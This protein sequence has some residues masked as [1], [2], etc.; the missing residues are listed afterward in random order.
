MTARCRG[1]TSAGPFLDTPAA[2]HWPANPTTAATS[3][4]RRRIDEVAIWNRRFRTRNSACSTTAARGRRWTCAASCADAYSVD[5]DATLTVDAASG[6]LAN[7]GPQFGEAISASVVSG[8][9]HGTLAI[10]R[11]RVVHLHASRELFW[12]RFVRLPDHEQPARAAGRGRDDHGQRLGDLPVAVDDF[13]R[14]REGQVLN[15]N[16]VP[17]PPVDTTLVAAG[18]V[19]KYL[20]NGSDQGTGWRERDFDDSALGSG[21]AELGYGDGGEAT[22]VDCGPAQGNECAAGNNPPNKYITTYFRRQFTIDDPSRVAG[23]SLELKRDDGAVV[24]INGSEVLRDNMG[25]GAINYLTTA[26]QALPDDGG[27][28]FPFS[29]IDRTS[30]VSGEN[31]IAV[32]IHQQSQQSSDISFDLRLDGMISPL[33]PIPGVLA[34]DSDPDGGTLTAVI[35]SLPDFGSLTFNANG[36]FVYTPAAGFNGTDAF[37]YRARNATGDSPPATVEIVVIPASNTPPTAV[38]DAYAVDEDGELIVPPRRGCWRTTATHRAI[39]C[40]R[41]WSP[42]RRTGS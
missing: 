18:S 10:G 20:D 23:L 14:T 31:V 30:L 12:R 36:T 40:L 42:A 33:P 24:Y 27:T 11:R 5:E 19:W 9:A 32:E 15:V 26:P 35:D 3:L 6:V 38:A 29:N 21:P 7:D 34:N 28:F 17:P 41:F 22:V 13:Y 2:T 8:P 4:F 25:G 1:L 37:T 39:H 16:P